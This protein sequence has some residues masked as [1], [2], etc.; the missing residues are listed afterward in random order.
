MF[1]L[2]VRRS[3]WEIVADVEVCKASAFQP[4]LSGQLDEG[5]I[6]GYVSA[7]HDERS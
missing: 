6:I 7:M 5:R 4:P 3:K 1:G 2:T